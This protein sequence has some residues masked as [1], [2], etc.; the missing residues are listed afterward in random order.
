MDIDHLCF[1]GWNCG[2]R[3]QVTLNIPIQYV[4]FVTQ[5]LDS[6]WWRHQMETFSALLALCAGN[7]PVTG[8]FP[9]QSQWRGALMLSLNCV[10][11]N[12]SV[13]NK[14][15]GDLRRYR[16]HY[17]VTVMD[18]YPRMTLLFFRRIILK[19][20]CQ[21]Y[22]VPK[23]DTNPIWFLPFIYFQ[24]YAYNLALWITS[25]VLYACICWYQICVVFQKLM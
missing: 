12:G 4:N 20:L 17:D 7:S 9:A 1:M 2:A 8:E 5:W 23:Y 15:A 13:N 11:I 16:A 10:W 25:F 21:I 18:C 6:A 24:Q 22:H 3:H 19:Y 14:D